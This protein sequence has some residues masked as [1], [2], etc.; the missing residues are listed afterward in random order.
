MTP[1]I[2]WYASQNY[3]EKNVTHESKHKS[4]HGNG[5]CTTPYTA[6]NPPQS[7][8]LKKFSSNLIIFQKDANYSVYYILVGSS[9]YF[10]CWHPSS[11]A[12]ITLNTAY[13]ID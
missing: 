12:R 6:E 13:G 2:Y 4:I 1:L 5:M 11:G 9:T 10:G 7:S 8:R 3:W